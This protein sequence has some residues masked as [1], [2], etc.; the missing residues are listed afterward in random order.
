MALCLWF[1]AHY[2]SIAIMKDILVPLHLVTLGLT[3]GRGY[4]IAAIRISQSWCHKFTNW[5]PLGQ[6]RNENPT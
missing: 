1:K 5:Q 4:G 2:P 6:A 3:I